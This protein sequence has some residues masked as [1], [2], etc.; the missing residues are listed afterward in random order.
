MSVQ[1]KIGPLLPPMIFVIE[2]PTRPEDIAKRYHN[3]IVREAMTATAEQHHKKHV[4]D[5]FKATNR[6]R[7]NHA[8]RSKKYLAYKIKRFR[9]RTDL[10]LTGRTKDWMTRAYKL[11]IGGNAEAGT[12]K[13]TMILTFPFKG[14]TG[15]F[16]DPQTFKAAQAQKTIQMMIREMETFADDEKKRLADWFL[17]YY[18]RGVEKFR[19]GRK[20]IRKPIT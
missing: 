5:H 11:R 20:R 13:A 10:V 1:A 19:S 2:I 17:E 7:Y 4:P 14:G 18:M 3:K 8:P 15:R 9:H 12:T 6:Q 16:K